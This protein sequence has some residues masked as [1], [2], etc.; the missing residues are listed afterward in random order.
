MTSEEPRNEDKKKVLLLGA[1]DSG[2]TSMRSI[3]FANFVARDTQKLASTVEV[4][5]SQVRFLGNLGLN[6]WDCGWQ[7]K[8][9]EAYF[10]VQKQHIFSSVAV[11]IFVFDITSRDLASDLEDFT[12]SIEALSQLSPQA[13]IFILIHKA[14]L[15]PQ[16][17]R[18]KMFIARRDQVTEMAKP[19]NAK[20]FLTS[21]W[22][23]SLYK[24]WSQI[25]YSM[26]PNGPLLQSNLEMFCE[27]TEVEEVVLFEKATFLDISH[28]THKRSK[29]RF[30]DVHRFEK[31]SNMI[32]M[33]KLGC[34]KSGGNLQTIHIKTAKFEA[35]LFD[36]TVHTYILAITDPAS[37]IESGATQLNIKSA[38]VHFDRLLN[39]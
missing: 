26:I 36:F 28:A 1:S 27:A 35:F 34:M 24:A 38:K 7:D 21:I 19:F 18:E 23:E 15:V 32:K 29:H 5:H 10:S 17:Q 4:E 2:K 11:M 20:C 30:K 9:K 39:S 33:F 31:I 6:L 14:D 16:D 8:W 22:E 3:I 13:K 25:V 12:N 37:G